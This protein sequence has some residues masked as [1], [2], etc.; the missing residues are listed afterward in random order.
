[1]YEIDRSIRVIGLV[2][3]RNYY[4]IQLPVDCVCL[5]VITLLSYSL[6]SSYHTSFNVNKQG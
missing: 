1:M 5:L 3:F 2:W 4:A 6:V